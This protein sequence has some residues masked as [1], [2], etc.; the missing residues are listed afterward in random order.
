[1]P[2]CAQKKTNTIDDIPEKNDKYHHIPLF[3]GDTRKHQHPFFDKNIDIFSETQ[4]EIFLGTKYIF[5]ER[6]DSFFLSYIAMASII[7]ILR[8]IIISRDFCG[9][10][11]RPRERVKPFHTFREV[12]AKM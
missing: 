5:G 8:Y 1:M 10:F 4:S 3:S 7:L 2:L 12:Y 11:L 6:D 9:F